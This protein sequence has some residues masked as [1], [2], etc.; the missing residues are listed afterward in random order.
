MNNDRMT[1]DAEANPFPDARRQSP[2]ALIFFAIKVITG[3]VRQW[4]P[5]LILIVA[6][7]GSGRKIWMALG[8]AALSA[9]LI[10]RSV[11][12]YFKFTFHLSGDALEVARGVLGRQKISL[13]FDRIQAVNFEQDLI[14]QVLNVV[15]VKI[16]T[17]GSSKDE[18]SL[19]ALTRADAE[20]LRDY[21]FANKKDP[22]SSETETTDEEAPMF[23]T[24]WLSLSV[25]DL[26][27]V[28][29]GQNHIRTA[30]IIIGFFFSIANRLEDAIGWNA[31]DTYY[32]I[33]GAETDSWINMA[34]IALS[35]FL[36]VS[37]AFSM[38][39][40]VLRY[41]G[42]RLWRTARGYR[43]TAGLLQRREQQVI[44]PKVQ[45]ARG[46]RTILER[47]LKQHTFTLKQ[48]SSKSTGGGNFV[49]P[50]LSSE[51]VSKLLKPIFGDALAADSDKLVISPLYRWRLI[52]RTGVLPAA[53]LAIAGY[54]TQ[55]WELI[56][57]AAFWLAIRFWWSFR[58]C[59]TFNISLNN[60]ILAVE[61]GVFT[62]SRDVLAYYK[63]QA[64][65]L[66][67]SPYQRRKQLGSLTLHTAG[68]D[69]Q[70]PFLPLAHAVALEDYF[71]YVVE[72]DQRPWM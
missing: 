24:P 71:L 58:F 64:V 56:P 34:L 4:W 70:M 31:E 42:L 51:H 7:N 35:F 44:F 23:N 61:R 54:F 15:K 12:S 45:L 33:V 16:D 38:G 39:R 40:T 67:Q 47:L 26:L 28:G 32:T 72:S 60:E 66:R 30:L 53:V 27:K 18:V 55:N 65:T 63:I 50:G 46:K 2:A 59:S 68:G 13:P 62:R 17:A 14:H 69:L 22:I 29:L 19:A 9:I 37:I 1:N 57:L 43:L 52:L 36:V 49:V 21:V 10:I 3:M 20:A 8:L 5:L 25:K 41:F 48:A 6:G 11:I